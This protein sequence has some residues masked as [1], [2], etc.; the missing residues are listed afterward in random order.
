MRIRT[1]KPEF[2]THE[3]LYDAER[4][5]EL[6]LRIAFIGLWCAA[7]RE[8]RFKW[9]ARRLGVLI[10]PYD[11]C[12]F[13]RVLDALT[14]RGFIQR[15]EVEG[16]AYGVIPSFSRHQ[17]VNPREKKSEIPPCIPRKGREGNRKGTDIDACKHTSRRA[18][19]ASTEKI[20]V[21]NVLSKTDG[22]AQ[23][24]DE[25]AEHRR[26]IKKPLT[27]L[28]SKHFLA[29]LEKRP[30]DAKAALQMGMSRSW[31]GFEWEWFD[32]DRGN[33]NGKGHGVRENL[34]LPV[35][36][37]LAPENGQ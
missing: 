6:P 13:S 35:F 2:F 36:D 29:K 27:P 30:A 33:G 18:E 31:Q 28:A 5:A 8:G 32:K 16:A 24:W 11:S 22:F 19:D 17:F 20:E 26:Q 14:T 9:E 3:A 12:D 15:Y 1:V 34:Q 10:L 23:T 21:P 37:P 7:D 4:E 25:F